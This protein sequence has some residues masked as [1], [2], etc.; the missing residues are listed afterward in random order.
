MCLFNCCCLPTSA[1]HA[2]RLAPLAETR[3]ELTARFKGLTAYIR[4]PA[5]GSWTGPDGHVEQDDVV[6]VEVVT[7]IFDR[8]WWRQYAAML[9]VRF[10]QA[11][12]Q[13]RAGRNFCAGRF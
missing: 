2:D 3:R 10:D 7:E 1:T 8:I 13:L 4:S 5:K 6:M 9:A 12:I 11:S